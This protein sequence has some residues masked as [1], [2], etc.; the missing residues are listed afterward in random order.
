MKIR[1]EGPADYPAI[2]ALHLAAFANEPH[3]RQTEPFIV[4][5][6]RAAQ[7]LT[8]GLV[9]EEEGVVVGHIA[10]SPAKINGAECGWYVLGPLGVAPA[11]QRQG[12]GGALIREGLRQLRDL[13]A[14]GCA[15]VGHPGY[16]ERFGF[17]HVAALS[18]EGIPPEVFFCMAMTEDVPAGKLTHH[19]AFGAGL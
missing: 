7:A 18:M 6:L 9:A 2:H 14:R 11:R 10:F 5:A 3:S 1:T 17:K 16:Y 4:E 19:E 15:L 13:G 12:I 8:I